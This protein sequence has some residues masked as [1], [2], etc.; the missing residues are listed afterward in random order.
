ME[1]LGSHRT[2]FHEMWYLDVFRN[3]C[4]YCIIIILIN[5]QVWSV[6]LTQ[7]RAG[8]KIEKNEMGGACCAC[9]WRGEVCTGFWWGNRRERDRWGDRGVD[10]RIMLGWIFRK[11]YVGVC[12]GLGW[13]MIGIGGGRLWVRWGTFGFHKTR[14][15]SWLAANRLASQEGLCSME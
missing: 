11:W 7:S 5:I 13:L 9:G 1:Q 10:G 12:T 4:Y 14:G 2:V 6:L 15:I 8:D 3:N